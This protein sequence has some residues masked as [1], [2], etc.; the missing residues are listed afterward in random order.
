MATLMNSNKTN[1]MFVN[2]SILVN[3]IPPTIMIHNWG[4]KANPYESCGPSPQ[5]G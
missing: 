3:L 5:V 2:T 1:I 4:P